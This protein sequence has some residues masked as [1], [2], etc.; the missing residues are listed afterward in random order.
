MLHHAQII[1]D[2]PILYDHS[3]RNAEHLH[4]LHYNS[5]PCGRD[6]HEIALVCAVRRPDLHYL[7]S[8]CNKIVGRDVQVREGGKVSLTESF[9]LLTSHIPFGIVSDEIG[10][11]VLF[12]SSYVVLVLE[13]LIESLDEI[14]V[15][16]YGLVLLSI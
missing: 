11:E 5:F 1:H 14:L 4:P 9:K 8:F 15:L 7:V 3:I 13:I 12:E 10:G 6:S 16:F 2:Y